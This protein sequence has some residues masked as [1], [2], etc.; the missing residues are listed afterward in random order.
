VS[1]SPVRS[2]QARGDVPPPVSPNPKGDLNNRVAA[3]ARQQPI[4]VDSDSSR[5]SS[6][7]R[8]GSPAPQEG[9]NLIRE[10]CL[11]SKAKKWSECKG[12][13]IVDRVEHLEPGEDSETC[14]CGHYPIREVCHIYN[15]VTGEQAIIGNRCIQ[16]LEGDG[17]G[18][19][20]KIFSALKRIE[21]DN[22]ASA[23]SELIEHAYERK[24]ISKAEYGFYLEI[25]RK[26][27]LSDSQEDWK[28]SINDKIIR[29]MRRAPPQAHVD[30]KELLTQNPALIAPASFVKEAY[31]AGKIPDKDYSFYNSIIDRGVTSP[32]PKQ[33]AWITSVNKKMLE[34]N[35][36]RERE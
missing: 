12:E 13:W 18:V 36:K 33:Q 9:W 7:D 11:L 1:I 31:E 21:S 35:R 28:I 10:L 16:K 6:P 8:T 17:D 32:T 2:S 5:A 34:G 22:T 14:I 25:W 30:P 4:L 29:S 19:I 26:R 24:T 3:V 20:Q 23:N 15:Q 27:N